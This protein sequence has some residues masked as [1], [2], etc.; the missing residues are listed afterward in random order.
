MEK[1]GTK[2]GPKN[3]FWFP[4]GTKVGAVNSVHLF[5]NASLRFPLVIVLNFGFTGRD[6]LHLL[7]PR[8]WKPRCNSSSE[9]WSFGH[10]NKQL[11]IKS[12][13][14]VERDFVIDEELMK[15]W[16]RTDEDLMKKWWKT[17]EDLSLMLTSNS[18]KHFWSLSGKVCLV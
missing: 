10:F 6:F 1:M 11:T 16:W 8:K 14:Y 7:R 3:S 17:D 9:I 18:W 12:H 4:M 5:E 13:L 2:W 15:K